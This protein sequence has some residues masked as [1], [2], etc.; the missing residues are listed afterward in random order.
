MFNALR[1]M[2]VFLNESKPGNKLILYLL[3]TFVFMK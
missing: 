2:H 3:S 1:K